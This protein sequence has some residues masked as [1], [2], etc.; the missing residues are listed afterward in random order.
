MLREN[1]FQVFENR[2]AKGI[3]E[4]ERKKATGDCRSCLMRRFIIDNHS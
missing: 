3:F 1:R 2:M 4:P